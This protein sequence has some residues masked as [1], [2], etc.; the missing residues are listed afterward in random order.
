MTATRK[1]ALVTGGTSG[2]GL[3]IVRALAETGADVYFIGTNRDKGRRIEEEL[4][5]GEGR[6][7]QLDLA[8]LH[9]VR[10]FADAFSADKGK[11]DVLVNAAGVMLPTREETSD[12]FEKT[13]AIDHFSAFVLS[14][15]L[16]PLLADALHGRIVNASGAPS[17]LLKPL[18]DFDDLQLNN[19][20]SFVR[21]TLNALHAK[22]VM[23]EVLAEKLKPDGIDVNAF[24]PGSVK[25]EIFQ[26]ME[27]PMSLVFRIA[28]IFMSKASTAGIHASTSDSLNAVTGQIFVGTTPHPL[29]FA[30]AYKDRLWDATVKA[31]PTGLV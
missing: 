2:V 1:T 31:L 15:A 14:R 5:Q 20:Y 21:A 7:V 18:L 27:F 30:R 3:S 8:D 16:A 24:H 22:T 13:L 11:L 9:A 6:F 29:N 25:S 19:N 26:H 23:T 17:Q 12:G 4:A 28:R 10:R